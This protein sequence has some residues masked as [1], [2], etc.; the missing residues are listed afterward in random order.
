MCER[1]R[2]IAREIAGG[3]SEEAKTSPGR[4][5]IRLAIAAAR[6]VVFIAIHQCNGKNR[7]SFAPAADKPNAARF[8]ART[9][10]RP[11]AIDYREKRTAIIGYYHV[12]FG[13]LLA[14]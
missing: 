12:R 3:E 1:E 11:Y 2:E 10:A 6:N 8:L 14:D 7:N 5:N 4:Q 13:I 9:A